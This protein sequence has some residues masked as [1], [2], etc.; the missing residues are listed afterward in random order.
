MS[1]DIR[2]P[3]L[4]KDLEHRVRFAIRAFIEKTIS[5]VQMVQFFF[6]YFFQRLELMYQGGSKEAR[7]I[8]KA[9]IN[10]Q[11]SIIVPKLVEVTVTTKST[12]ELSF[13]SGIDIK[14]PSITFDSLKTVLDIILSSTTIFKA[15]MDKRLKIKKFPEILKWLAPIATLQTPETLARIQEADLNL[16]KKSL[17]NIGY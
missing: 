4:P 10:Q 1:A 6:Q 3:P 9:L 8:N 14:N 15:Y 5:D 12:F 2:F 13:T 17:L 7:D 11:F 16:I